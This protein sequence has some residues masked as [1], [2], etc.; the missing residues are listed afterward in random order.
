MEAKLHGQ[1]TCTSHS[2]YGKLTRDNETDGMTGTQYGSSF[3]SKEGS[4]SRSG[5]WS[6]KGLNLISYLK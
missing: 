2:L 6:G 4:R 3:A 1:L 5:C